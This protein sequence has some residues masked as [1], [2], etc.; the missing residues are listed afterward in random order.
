[1]EYLGIKFDEEKNKVRGEQKISADDSSKVEVW[2][3]P[4]NEELLIARDTVEIV[5]KAK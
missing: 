5:N 1:M 3:I 2:V 4:T